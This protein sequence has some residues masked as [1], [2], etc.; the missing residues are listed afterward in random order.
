ME[1][2]LPTT[3]SQ[4]SYTIIANNI[5]YAQSIS[6]IKLVLNKES[7]IVEKSVIQQFLFFFKMVFFVNKH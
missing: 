4:M 1:I 2:Y 3:N 7:T 6:K 5:I